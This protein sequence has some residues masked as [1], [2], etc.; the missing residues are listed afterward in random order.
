MAGLMLPW[1]MYAQ[2][3]ADTIAGKV[4]QIEH[5]TVTARR[6]PARITSTAPVQILSGQDIDRLGI[7]DMMEV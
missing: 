7:Q 1:Q 3:P 2:Q 6:L 4:H 5:V